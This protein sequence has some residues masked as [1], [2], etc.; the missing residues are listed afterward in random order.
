MIVDGSTLQVLS[1]DTLLKV[2]HLLR[3]SE[4]AEYK[5]RFTELL[6]QERTTRAARENAMLL[7]AELGLDADGLE[8]DDQVDLRDFLRAA[9]LLAAQRREARAMLKGFSAKQFGDMS[10]AFRERAVDGAVNARDLAAILENVYPDLATGDNFRTYLRRVVERDE[11]GDPL[12]FGR[13]AYERFVQIVEAFGALQDEDRLRKEEA[14]RSVASFSRDEVASFRDLFLATSASGRFICFEELKRMLH[15]IVPLCE[16]NI[17]RLQEVVL[18][19]LAA[20]REP[21]GLPLPWGRDAGSDPAARAAERAPSRGSAAP[22][23]PRGPKSG[24]LPPRSKGRAWKDVEL[25]FPD[26]LRLMQA[27]VDQDFAG[28]QQAASLRAEEGAGRQRGSGGVVPEGL[29]R[30]LT[31]PTRA[32]RRDSESGPTRLAG[33]RWSAAAVDSDTECS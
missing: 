4:L 18:S 28:L 22:S 32:G 3:Q 20:P 23:P 5:R 30:R 24:A 10:R 16:A 26:F 8:L 29:P 25:D 9:G 31:D 14:A 15:Q 2:A 13:I 21:A 33:T 11:D 12:E 27:L 7:L 19:S 6:V 17:A 1:F